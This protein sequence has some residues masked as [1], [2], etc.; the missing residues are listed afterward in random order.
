[1][2][3]LNAEM[4]KLKK[5]ATETKKINEKI[6]KP[7]KHNSKMES[8]SLQQTETNNKISASSE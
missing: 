3:N 6:N 5:T 1:M 8:W 7:A 4:M 2:N